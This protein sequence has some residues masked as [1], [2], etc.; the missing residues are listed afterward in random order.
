MSVF[1]LILPNSVG[2]RGV[3]HRRVNSMPVGIDFDQST[4]NYI[5]FVVLQDSSYFYKNLFSMFLCH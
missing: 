3:I 1:V 4:Q 5:I 2:I